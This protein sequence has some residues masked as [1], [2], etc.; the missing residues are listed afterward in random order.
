VFAVFDDEARALDALSRAPMRMR[1]FVTR[2]LNRSPLLDRLNQ[3]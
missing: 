2:G 3:G 1:G